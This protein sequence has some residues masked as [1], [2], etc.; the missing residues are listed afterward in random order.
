MP[1]P[2]TAN[3]ITPSV[4]SE[5][6]VDLLAGTYPASDT[7]PGSDVYPGRGTDL[8]NS[9]VTPNVLAASAA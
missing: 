3:T 4:L 8:T 1:T 2:L 5:S 7:Y 9:T 6:S